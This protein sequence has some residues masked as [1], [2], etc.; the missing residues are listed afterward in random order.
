MKITTADG[1]L[2][3]S[4]VFPS[5]ILRFF[6]IFAFSLS[7]CTD[8]PSVEKEILIGEFVSKTGT[9]AQF[10]KSVEHGVQL[11]VDEINARGGIG[12]NSRNNGKARVSDAKSGSGRIVRVITIETGGEKAKIEKAVRDFAKDSRVMAIIGE[13]S[14]EKSNWAAKIAQAEKLPM[15]SPASTNPNV[16]ENGP[17]IFR[18][19]YIDPFQ[20]S[21]MATFAFKDLQLKRVMILRHD[22]S[23]Y[24]LGLSEYFSEK[25][26]KLGGEILA[27]ETYSTAQGLPDLV[28]QLA[29]IKRLKP[30][31]IFIPVYYSEA[32]YLAKKI[33]GAGIKSVFLGG[34]GWDSPFLF[35]MDSKATEGVNKAVEGVYFSNH[36]SAEKDDPVVQKFVSKYKKEFGETPDGTAAMGYDA[37]RIAL[38]AIQRAAERKKLNR[39]EV[40]KELSRTTGFEGVSGTITIDENRNAKKSIVV[41]KS[42]NKKFR[43]VKTIQPD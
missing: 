8:S 26:I 1:S 35:D 28:D 17:F 6:L 9:E 22:K 39:D 29:V 10:G 3:S 21:A 13:V 38:A 31:A 4:L 14:S 27:E 5:L 19:C 23:N 20:G 25:F 42:E 12:R 15:I 11:A 7:G 24:S 2:T 34:D 33:R 18:A 37:A 32:A 40:R 41:L 16:T 36:F 30:Q 43:Y